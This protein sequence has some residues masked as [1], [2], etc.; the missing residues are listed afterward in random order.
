MSDEYLSGSES[1]HG[2]LRL[3]LSKNYVKKR[4]LPVTE[5]KKVLAASEILVAHA[6]INALF[7]K[8]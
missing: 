6:V 1:R 3:R 4:G 5:S 7:T 8:Q 2:L